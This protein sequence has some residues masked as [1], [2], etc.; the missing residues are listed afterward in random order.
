MVAISAGN[1][2]ELKSKLSRCKA[3]CSGLAMA[4]SRVFSPRPPGICS[5]SV[6]Q[7]PPNPNGSGD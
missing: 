6:M 7:R 5:R 1:V 2:T 3:W 4:G